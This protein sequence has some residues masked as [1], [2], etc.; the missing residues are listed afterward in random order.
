MELRKEKKN[1]NVNLLQVWHCARRFP[2]ILIWCFLPSPKIGTSTPPSSISLVRT[3]RIKETKELAA[4]QAPLFKWQ[5]LNLNLDFFLSAVLTTVL[6][7]KGGRKGTRKI[8]FLS[9]AAEMGT[10]K[11]S[12]AGSASFP[13]YQPKSYVHVHTRPH[14]HTGYRASQTVDVS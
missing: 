3:L 13:S 9:P 1:N 6:Y 4:N 8:A 11:R 10:Q 5:S 14:A 12:V 7:C 2:G